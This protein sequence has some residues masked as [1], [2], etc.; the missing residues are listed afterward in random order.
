ML[1][2]HM[3]Q[4]D[5]NY[6]PLLPSSASNTL[7]SP[8]SGSSS[9][10]LS[11]RFQGQGT[12]LPFRRAFPNG[13][14]LQHLSLWS[15]HLLSSLVPG[16]QRSVCS[17]AHYSFPDIICGFLSMLSQLFLSGFLLNVSM[18][19]SLCVH[20]VWGSL[21]LNMDTD[22]FRQFFFKVLAVVSLDIFLFPS[23]FWHFH[24]AQMPA[25]LNLCSLSS[26]SVC[27]RLH[28]LIKC[29]GNIYFSGYM[30]DL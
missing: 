11:S 13:S 8:R 17:L 30:F 24:C 16:D 3:R 6:C 5:L 23:F 18:C 21:I 10:I 19:L 26:F 7:H 1:C 29:A 28:C 15:P 25:I 27:F 9:N 20:P 12:P 22:I 14:C 4:S 2:S